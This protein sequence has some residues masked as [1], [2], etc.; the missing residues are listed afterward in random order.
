[1]RRFIRRVS[2]FRNGCTT[3]YHKDDQYKYKLTLHAEGHDVITLRRRTRGRERH[4]EYYVV[5]HI[6][7][8][9]AFGGFFADGTFSASTGTEFVMAMLGPCISALEND[10]GS[11]K[12]IA[13]VE[14]SCLE[15]ILESWSR[16]GVVAP[17]QFAKYHIK[18][19]MKCSEC[20]ESE[21]ED[22]EPPPVTRKRHYDGL[23]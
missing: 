12:I 8:Y 3:L 22:E 2:D 5:E 19:G 23:S 18:F 20:S 11:K 1:M 13:V 17:V 4:T 7:L 15:V 6:N 21:M 14:T 10:T 16:D 9:R